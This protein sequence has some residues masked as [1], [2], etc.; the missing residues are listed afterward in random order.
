MASLATVQ[1]L[2]VVDVPDEFIV[3]YYRELFDERFIRRQ[4]SVTGKPIKNQRGVPSC[5]GE[6]TAYAKAAD[7]KVEIS[8]RDGYRLAKRKEN[9]IDLLSWGTSIWCALDA[10]MD[11]GV[12]S[13]KAVPDISDKPLSVYVGIGDVTDAVVADRAK[14]KT[15]RTYYVPRTEMVSTLWKTQRP[16]VTSCRWYSGDNFM[17]GGIMIGASGNDV[18]GHAF[19]AIGVVRRNVD[20]ISTRCLAVLNSWSEAWGDGGVFYIPLNSTFNRLGNGYISVDIGGSLAD[21]LAKYDGRLVKVYGDPKIWKIENGSKRH[22]PS[23]REFFSF[24]F[25]F[26]DEIDI[27]TDE[28]DLIPT[29]LPMATIEADPKMA[30][31]FRQIAQFFGH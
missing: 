31:R 13:E 10:Q 4:Q 21:I 2:S 12:A 3:P 6:S 24:G 7:E 30:E 17:A 14:H 28:L 22:I 8:G 16:I 25:I 23:E 29:G 27:T 1:S 20:G 19:C 15:S 18:G 26:G 9:P 11:T 5:V